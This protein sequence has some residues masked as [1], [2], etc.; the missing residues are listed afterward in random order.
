[1]EL[2]ELADVSG[3]RETEILFRVAFS[4][5]IAIIQVH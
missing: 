5:I 3:G 1:M 4:S 2:L